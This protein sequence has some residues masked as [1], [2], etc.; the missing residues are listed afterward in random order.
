MGSLTVWGLRRALF[1]QPRC[2]PPPLTK[3]L[4]PGFRAHPD[5]IRPH[6]NWH[7]RRPTSGPWPQSAPQPPVLT[8]PLPQESFPGHLPCSPLKPRRPVLLAL[9]RP[10]TRHQP[11]HDTQLGS[12]GPRGPILLT[13]A[14][15]WVKTPEGRPHLLRGPRSWHGG[16]NRVPHR[17]LGVLCGGLGAPGRAG[18]SSQVP[19]RLASH[20][21][22]ARGW[23]LN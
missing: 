19:D 2:V 4:V 23:A 7:L 5:P 17:H 20:Q 15:A 21:P 11:P 14:S 8:R 10:L 16:A 3:T 1:S 9:L 22:A 12:P 18:P 6:L 13:V